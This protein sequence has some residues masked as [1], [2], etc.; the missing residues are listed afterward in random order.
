MSHTPPP[1]P[2]WQPSPQ[3]TTPKPIATLPPLPV[4]QQ[5]EAVSERTGVPVRPATI[6]VAHILLQLA[7]AG[8][9]VAYGWHWYRAAF[10]ETYPV[11]AHLI[12]WVA[13]DPGKWLSLTLEGVL[14]AATALVGGACGVAGFQAWNGW[15]WSR[16][17]G[18]V[19]VVLT[20]ALVA[21]LNWVALAAVVPAVAG[22]VLLFLPAATGFFD[23]FAR[24]R[25]RMP[26]PYRRPEQII[27]GRLP[28]FR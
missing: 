16:W 13:P 22:A 28:R 26:E 5:H 9:A 4:L 14:A 27:Y 8:V 23:R 11:S 24:H 7:V 17:A 25:R 3:P 21:V 15:R 2:Q 19:A 12:Q 10:P 6:L 1:Q 18:V 20:G